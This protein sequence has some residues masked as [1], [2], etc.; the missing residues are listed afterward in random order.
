MKRILYLSLV[1][2]LLL[3]T[4][5]GTKKDGD[6][7]EYKASIIDN[8]NQTLKMSA[9]ELKQILDENEAKFKKYYVGSKISF[10]G[11]VVK[12]ENDSFMQLNCAD[13]TS[14]IRH[15]SDIRSISG[16]DYY[17]KRTCAKISF[18]EGFTLYIPSTGILDLS[19]INNGDRYHIESNIGGEFGNIVVFGLSDTKATEF[20][21][22]KIS[23]IK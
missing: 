8:E 5:C 18:K 10:D 12:V 7:K 4:G 1:I 9:K 11:T 22:S 3:I 13:D 16:V 17:D 21:N 15:K 6:S 20:D 14:Y 2:I 19:E 23:K